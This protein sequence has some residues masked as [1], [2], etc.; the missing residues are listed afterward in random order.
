MTE[1]KCSGC[2]KPS[3]DRFRICDCP[4]NCVSD[5]IGKTAWKID[6]A[7]RRLAETIRTLI[8]GIAPEDQDVVL[9]DADWRL[10]LELL[11]P[12]TTARPSFERYQRS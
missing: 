8:L 10:I 6:P 7:P 4:T 5:M 1:W 12:Q 3:P 9:E 11:E 2:G